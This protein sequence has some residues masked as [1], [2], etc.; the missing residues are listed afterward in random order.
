MQGFHLMELQSEGRLANWW[1]TVLF[2]VIVIIAMTVV[3]TVMIIMIVVIVMMIV[4]I[5]MTVVI[6]MMIVMIIMIVVIV[7]VIV[8]IIMIIVRTLS[9]MITS[10]LTTI[11]VFERQAVSL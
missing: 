3:M 4:M 6:V 7:M 1:K 10:A 2:L 9:T 5:I 11:I 8:M